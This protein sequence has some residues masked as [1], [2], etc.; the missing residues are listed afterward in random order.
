MEPMT[1]EQLKDL[2]KTLVSVMQ[3]ADPSM[4]CSV[5]DDAR[6][7]IVLVSVRYTAQV[8]LDEVKKLRDENLWIDL[9]KKLVPIDWDGVLQS[10][11]TEKQQQELADFA[12]AGQPCPDFT[13]WNADVYRH[14]LRRLVREVR[15]ERRQI[16]KA[17]LAKRRLKVEV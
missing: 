15:D 13:R 16:E 6:G 11:L 2:L 10:R 1:Y 14:H 4:R 8:F 17:R 9:I 7:D 5:I 12:A 3:P